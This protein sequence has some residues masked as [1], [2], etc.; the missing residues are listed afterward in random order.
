MKNI[1]KIQLLVLA[2]L[3]FTSQTIIEAQDV[4]VKTVNGIIS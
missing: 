1:I 4:K 3:T 2:F